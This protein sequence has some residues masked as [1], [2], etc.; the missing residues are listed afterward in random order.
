MKNKLFHGS[1]QQD[2]Q[3]FLRCLLTQIHDEI[4]M[5]V[6]DSLVCGCGRVSCDRNCCPPRDSM[7]SCTSHDSNVSAESLHQKVVANSSKNSPLLKKR[8]KHSSQKSSGVTTHSAT[9][10]SPTIQP[11]FSFNKGKSKILAASAGSK[12]S[13]ESIPQLVSHHGGSKLSL[14]PTSETVEEGLQWS[15]DDLVVVD[16]ITRTVTV[17]R[18]YFGQPAGAATREEGSLTSK[19]SELTVPSSRSRSSTPTLPQLTEQQPQRHK[20]L[21]SKDSSSSVT[22]SDSAQASVLGDVRGRADSQTG[23]GGK[24]LTPFNKKLL[25]KIL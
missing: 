24:E 1:Q 18:Q 7:V 21:R 4:K 23:E 10:V 6:P 12:T 13:V 20:Q 15:R 14:E 8:A 2:A 19:M 5:T 3:E 22:S 17:H 11:K 9:H 16:L 25:Y